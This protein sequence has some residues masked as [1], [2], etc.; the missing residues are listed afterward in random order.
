MGLGANS[1][2]QLRATGE[3]KQV[4]E[5]VIPNVTSMDAF[6]KEL[7]IYIYKNINIYINISYKI[8]QRWVDNAEESR[9]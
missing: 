4:E 3:S 6:Y 2:V 8:T 1:R 9:C 7:T 5:N